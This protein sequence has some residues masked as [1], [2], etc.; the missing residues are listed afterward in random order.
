MASRRSV[1][2]TGLGPISAFGMGMEPLWDALVEGRS[3]VRPIERFDASGF[4]CSI[5]AELPDDLFNVKKVV[6]KSYRKATKVMAR[7]IELAV[8][9]ALAAIEDAGLTTKGTDPE[10]PPSI[11]PARFGCHIGAGLIAAEVDELTSALYE[12]R[13][14]AGDGIDLRDWGEK[15]M[16]NLT[17]LWLLKYL[18]NMLA[19]HVTI[20]HDCR[21][22]SNTITCAEAS[23]AL[24]L[25]ESVRVIQRRQADACLTGGA[26]AKLNPM[27]L[28]RQHFAR[29]L[30]TS[31]GS[32]DP[33]SVV[34]P[35]GRSAAGSVLGEGGGILVLEGADIAESRGATVYAE[36]AGF[37]STQSWCPD[38]VGLEF[39]PEDEG[40]ADAVRIALDDAGIGPDDIDAI[41]PFGSAIPNSD[42]VERHAFRTVLGDRAASVP[43]V[44]TVPNLGNCCAGA[45]AISLAVAAKCLS[46]QKLP[47]RLNTTDADGL[48]ANACD[49]RD[50]DLRHIL[51][52]TT[53]MGG[54]NTAVVL[55]RR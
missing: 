30:A 38:T 53:S 2:I 52:T 13:N 26:E 15:G 32:T 8:G 54:Q 22:P 43:L 49:A 34:R 20:I 12:S 29:R 36:V 21:G 11:D 10:A 16:H 35:F 50:A 19:C 3:A 48:D 37:A 44:T 18:P 6:P 40:V 4:P 46:E 17:P 33:A 42:A 28:L 23:S 1:L 41:V 45:S 25:G 5:G 51:V 9:G 55:R 7:D 27:G 14:D 24:S 39:D 47:A 31:N